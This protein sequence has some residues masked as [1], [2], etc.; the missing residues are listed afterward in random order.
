MRTTVAQ[1]Y[2]KRRCK[3]PPLAVFLTKV[4]R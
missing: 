1:V 3:V 2:L 4:N